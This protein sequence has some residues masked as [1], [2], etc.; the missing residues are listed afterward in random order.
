MVMGKSAPA[1]T[2]A[3][4]AS[5]VLAALSRVA[6]PTWKSTLALISTVI[7]CAPSVTRTWPPRERLEH[8][9]MSSAM[10]LMRAE[11]LTLGRHDR[12]GGTTA[13]T[14]LGDTASLGEGMGITGG[15]IT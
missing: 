2:P 10:L 9:L 11:R 6:S 15:T 3:T 13:G 4:A 12:I 7:P 1:S 8:R 5:A 14:G